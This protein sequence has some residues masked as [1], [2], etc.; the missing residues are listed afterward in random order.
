MSGG[1]YGGAVRLVAVMMILL[2]LVILVRTFS[3]GGGP[4]SFGAV[5]GLVMTG[6]GCA[7]LWL[8]IKLGGGSK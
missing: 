6:I 2:G 4:F 5:V 3:L 7:R 8:A 1:L